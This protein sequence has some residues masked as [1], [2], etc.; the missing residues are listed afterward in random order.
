MGTD[1]VRFPMTR[2]CNKDRTMDIIINDEFKN[3][4]PPLHIDE[5]R[6]LEQSMLAHGCRDALVV[7]KETDILLDG[8][9]RHRICTEHNIPFTAVDISLPDLDTAKLWI[10]SNQLSRRNLNPSQ[11]RYF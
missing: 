7:W 4:I 9:N 11:M 10:I 3:L 5:F 2:T 1:T 8:Y 6:A